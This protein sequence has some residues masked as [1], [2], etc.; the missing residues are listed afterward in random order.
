MRIDLE[1]NPLVRALHDTRSGRWRVSLSGTVVDPA[2]TVPASGVRSVAVRLD[3]HDD[4]W[5]TATVDTSV[6]PHIW[7]IDYILGSL[8]EDVYPTG[9]YTVSVR[10]ID[11]A[12]SDGNEAIVTAPMIIDSTPP[13]VGP[14]MTGE[15]LLGS[16]VATA[17]T[18]GGVITDPGEVAS[19]L[20]EIEIA[21]MPRDVV[22]NPSDPSLYLPM[23]E[24]PGETT[25]RDLDNPLREAECL[26]ACPTAGVDGRFGLALSYGDT[27]TGI[28]VADVDL[29]LEGYSLIVW[30]NTTCADCGLATVKRGYRDITTVRDRVLYLADGNVYA[31]AGP[32]Y[33]EEVIASTGTNYAD[34][35]WHMVVH[36][37]GPDGHAL[38]LDGERAALGVE[39]GS[40]AGSERRST[41]QL[42]YAQ[43]AGVG[44][45]QGL[46]DEALAYGVQLTPEQVRGLYQAWSAFAPDEAGEGVVSS[47][48][49]RSI[50]LGL[51]G[52]YQIDLT[53]SDQMGNRNDARSTWNHWRGE[54]DTAPPRVGLSVTLSG[55]GASAKTT[56]EGWAEDAN[57]ASVRRS[58]PGPAPAEATT[59]VG[60]VIRTVITGTVDGL[61]EGG[62]ALK[63]CDANG[64][65][66]VAYAPQHH[67]YWSDDRG[68]I[69]RADLDL[70]NAVTVRAP[71]TDT[72]GS[73]FVEDWSRSRDTNWRIPGAFALGIDAARG[74]L[75]WSYQGEDWWEGVN[76]IQRASLESGVVETIAEVKDAIN[77]RAASDAG[78]LYYLGPDRYGREGRALY[79]ANLDGTNP[80]YVMLLYPLPTSRVSVEANPIAFDLDPAGERIFWVSPPSSAY[81]NSTHVHVSGL[82]GQALQNLPG[83]ASPTGF[84]KGPLVYN[85]STKSVYWVENG[86]A[87]IR[88]MRQGMAD[89]APTQIVELATATPQTVAD[90]AVDPAGRVLYWRVKGSNVLQAYDMATERTSALEAPAPL[91]GLVLGMTPSRPE[92]IDLSVTQQRQFVTTSDLL[93]TVTVRNAGP[94]EA[95][96]V[97]L[98]DTLPVQG[99][100]VF[101]KASR[102]ACET[103]DEGIAT[104][105]LGDL[106][107]RAE[108]TVTLRLELRGDSAGNVVNEAG[109]ASRFLPD[110]NLSNNLSTDTLALQSDLSIA[111]SHIPVWS[112]A[113]EDIVYR[114]GITN[115]RLTSTGTVLTVTL[116]TTA[117]VLS[118]TGSMGRVRSDAGGQVVYDVGRLEAGSRAEVVVTWRGGAPGVY[119]GTAIV[120]GLREDPSP[121]DN[122]L[123]TYT[124]LM[125][126]EWR[127]GYVLG[128]YDLDAQRAYLSFAYENEGVWEDVAPVSGW[129][130][131]LAV[132]AVTGT[133]YRAS[134]NCIFSMPLAGGKWSQGPCVSGG[135][136]IRDLVI[137]PATRT[138]YWVQR[139]SDRIWEMRLDGGE[140]AIS[141][142][143]GYSFRPAIAA[144]APDGQG[145]V[146][147]IN[148]W[149]NAIEYA[150]AGRPE[151]ELILQLGIEATAIAFDRRRGELYWTGGH[152]IYR[153]DPETGEIDTVYYGYVEDD[154]VIDDDADRLYWHN[155]Q[156]AGTLRYL[157]LATGEL[158]TVTLPKGIPALTG[159]IAIGWRPWTAPP[160]PVPTHSATPTLTRTPSQISTRTPTRTSTPTPTHT[161][162]ATPTPVGYGQYD[163][164][165]SGGSPVSFRVIAYPIN[166][167]DTGYARDVDVR[168]RLDPGADDPKTSMS[169]ALRSPDGRE[170]VLHDTTSSAAYGSG[171]IAWQLR[172][173]EFDDEAAQSIDSTTSPYVGAFGPQ[174][175]LAA[176]RDAPSEGEWLL[177]I[178]SGSNAGS[179]S[180]MYGVELEIIRSAEPATPTPSATPTATRTPT[181]SRTPTVGPS[182]TPSPTME[183]AVAERLYWILSE[184]I[185][186]APVAGCI[187]GS[188]IEDVLT[189]EG[190][191]PTA[192]LIDGDTM[193]WAQASSEEGATAIRRANLDGT[194]VAT[195][196]GLNDVQVK[197]LALD[198]QGGYIYWLTDSGI[199]RARTDGM[200]RETIIPDLP[201]EAIALDLSAGKVYWAEMNSFGP[202]SAVR[203]ANL[204]G[205]DVATV[206]ESPDPWDSMTLLGEPH[207]LAVDPVTGDLYVT[208]RVRL[209]SSGEWPR[210]LLRVDTDCAAGLPAT[211]E[212]VVDMA[213]AEQ[214]WPEGL[215]LDL[216]TRTAYV[217]VFLA[218][219]DHPI[220][221][222]GA[223]YG[224]GGF[225]DLM[226]FDD[227]LFVHITHVALQYTASSGGSSVGMSRAAGRAE[228]AQS[229]GLT[230]WFP[231]AYR[232]R[233]HQV[234][235]PVYMY[236]S[237]GGTGTSHITPQTGDT[238]Y[239]GRTATISGVAYG[240]RGLRRV[241]VT[242]D[243]EVV[244]TREWE[245]DETTR[246]YWE[247][248][249][250]PTEEH[251]G[252]REIVARATDWAGVTQ[253]LASYARVAVQPASARLGRDVPVGYAPEAVSS[254][255]LEPA[256]GAVLTSLE[257]I[258]VRVGATADASLADLTVSVNGVPLD[259]GS[260]SWASSPLTSTIWTLQWTPP[261]SGTFEFTS[262]AID[263][264]GVAQASPD[265]VVVHVEPDPPT[266]R[267]ARTV[268]T[269]TRQVEP[270]SVDLAGTFTGAVDAV[271][272]RIGDDTPWR[273]ATIE[274]NTWTYR[275]FQTPNDTF[276]GQIT[277][278]WVRAIDGAGRRAEITADVTVDVTPP[279][280]VDATLSALTGGGATLLAEGDTVSDASVPMAIDW[281]EAT[282]SSGIAGYHVD[283]L[284][285][286]TAPNAPGV[287]HA[288]DAA[289]HHEEVLSDVGV[290]W[291]HVG[292]S[293]ALG[294]W[295]WRV[296]GPIHVDGVTT[297]DLVTSIG[298]AWEALSYDGWT[299]SGCTLVGS[300][301]V[302][303]TRDP[304]RLYVTW[305]DEALRLRWS[306]ASWDGE[307][308][309]FVYL[310]TKPGGAATA[311][312]P[313]GA[314]A[315][316]VIHLPVDD[317]VAMAADY[318]LW[319]AGMDAAQLLAWDGAT[320]KA[321]SRLDEAR[322]LLTN[323]ARP[324]LADLRIP[325]SDLG[326]TSP[327][328][329]S[330]RLVAFASEEGVLRPWA[331]MPSRNPLT[332]P[333]HADGG[334]VITLAQTYAWRPR[335]GAGH[336]P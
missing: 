206:I 283:W 77:L 307:G 58:W 310:D 140:P 292:A 71:Y 297:P 160:T 40:V 211:G 1:G 187:D 52:Q 186:R 257:P 25:F 302:A 57:L 235:L 86:S 18:V 171:S 64:R 334:R 14:L 331:V 110:H 120:A 289:H 45:Y 130:A 53:G 294:N 100:L 125:A 51:E 246:A 43:V 217:G 103:S 96:D 122:V 256:H 249:W 26:D 154:L 168:L 182:P 61:Q 9:Q 328:G 190:G 16:P 65:C 204:D 105:T 68:A 247:T 59:R 104:C 313:Y 319:V 253:T 305:D 288:A 282:D 149:Q 76:R 39:T 144:V 234:Y 102:G 136:Q 229:G 8:G 93:Y 112:S 277:Q 164:I 184:T 224:A 315:D 54:I 216:T 188:C 36:T 127:R 80:A 220:I 181:P 219:Y 78:H 157:D 191:Y 336:R 29:P 296:L 215:A 5:Q 258:I 221:Q 92:T 114:F 70:T 174:N 69:M 88:L 266:V 48:W 162:T 156:H 10:A 75:Y 11:N 135:A 113:G 111:E 27:D 177:I 152:Y 248:S 46:L 98:T 72:H 126:K 202:S 272:V 66:A 213:S 203:R 83:S 271:Q 42:G 242:V 325:F 79:R 239:V 274:S 195:V 41:V 264:N 23:D 261:T 240:V 85:A 20:K 335:R 324:A 172:W 179:R 286:P 232:Q 314:E 89:A 284:T 208:T 81:G 200:G 67:L 99:T 15:S 73:G 263:A 163:W 82:R 233:V 243:G 109:V 300:S 34:G 230:T 280:V 60:D 142:Y 87:A 265:G 298:M 28:E 228:A 193:Y 252:V 281:G 24:L 196:I 199:E 97:V 178:T 133:L 148:D 47:T 278:V 165:M 194:G 107:P 320:W 309:L 306:G 74:A 185:Q 166:A 116:P 55:Q 123:S 151:G 275:W 254:A 49:S 50:P 2:S 238:L 180:V 231:L 290:Y 143:S 311:Y 323:A 38:Y 32:T 101:A 207:D 22:D 273:D 63:A 94:L 189:E 269:S 321:V 222:V 260:G 37:V 225:A 17:L 268:Y 132:D 327:T 317:G 226:V 332:G 56:Y 308:D 175:A 139:Y 198:R 90:L 250:T 118:V 146:Y 158:G 159:Y 115:A 30:F 210:R 241:V 170:V 285:S 276:D 124:T 322:L 176:F 129:V 161:P 333:T 267:L 205:T 295:G 12:V 150:P 293:D 141:H 167:P 145:G 197:D 13:V 227:S 255:I 137:D 183:P 251:L 245:R 108:V 262:L 201:A 95:V 303:S 3:P 301:A 326:I 21:Y 304:Q 316:D 329:T 212:C 19:G 134:G 270:G 244:Y 44:G 4:G 91:R 84:T 138:M 259:T 209:S 237:T 223:D 7:A 299:A 312:D 117:T 236:P 106:P 147:W 318:A 6:T 279:L 62:G 218:D 155:F 291:A 169:I 192:L 33:D 128:G 121:T 31:V 35:R 153:G 119:A 330:L 131:P 214:W 287:T 173:G